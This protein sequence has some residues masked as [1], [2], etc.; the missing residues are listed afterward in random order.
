MLACLVC[1]MLAY[2]ACTIVAC[3]VRTYFN[4]RVGYLIYATAYDATHTSCLPVVR[5]RICNAYVQCSLVLVQA[6][7]FH[8]PFNKLCAS[9]DTPHQQ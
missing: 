4:E 2:V 5:D 6:A 9:T 7:L 1:T 3:V 8:I